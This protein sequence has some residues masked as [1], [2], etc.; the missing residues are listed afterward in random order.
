M[1]EREKEFEK[2]GEGWENEKR[3]GKGYVRVR[4]G[5]R[6]REEHGKKDDQ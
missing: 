6:E 1:W 5:E 4:L 3:L 2:S